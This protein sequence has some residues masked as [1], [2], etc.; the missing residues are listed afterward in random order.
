MDPVTLTTAMWC[1]RDRDCQKEEQCCKTPLGQKCFAT[2]DTGKDDLKE[3]DDDNDCDDEDK[4]ND[5]KERHSKCHRHGF[6][7]PVIVTAIVLGVVLLFVVMITSVKRFCVRSKIGNSQINIRGKDP[8]GRS[9]NYIV[10]PKTT[11]LYDSTKNTRKEECWIDDNPPPPYFIS[12]T[13]PP[14]YSIDPPPS[15]SHQ[16]KMSG[17]VDKY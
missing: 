8:S 11:G 6:I 13:A 17:H 4:K 1:N 12:P 16:A 7:N 9:S 15:Y 14:A 10:K 3:N 2:Q 5:N